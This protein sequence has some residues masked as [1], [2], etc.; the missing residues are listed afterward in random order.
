MKTKV[1]KKNS[2][3]EP[4]LKTAG[5]KLKSGFPPGI[6]VD[7]LWLYR[8]KRPSE[9][10]W[11]NDNLKPREGSFKLLKSEYRR[12]FKDFR[13]CDN[14]REEISPVRNVKPDDHLK[15][16]GSY[17]L[18]PLYKENFIQYPIERP[19]HR[20]TTSSFQIID[21]S[22]NEMREN[23]RENER[24]LTEIRSRYPPYPYQERPPL[25]KRETNLK[26][27]GDLYT[28]TEKAEKFI[29][30]LLT[31]KPPLM[32]KPT[33]LKLEGEMDI[34]TENR[35]KY[36]PYEIAP[37]P[38]LCKKF[39]NLHLEGDLNILTEKQE[40]FIR[41][42]VQKR[43][44]L[45][46]KHTNLVIEG[47]LELLPEYRRE[48]IEYKTERPKLALPVN[49]LKTDGF[50]D[51]TPDVSV[52]FQQQIHP[53][54]PNLR[55]GE[56]HEDMTLRTRLGRTTRENSLVDGPLETDESAK[57]TNHLHLEGRIDL[58]PE[59]R[60]AYIDF[61]KEVSAP[62][63]RRR[64]PES[65]LKSE[66]KMDI[67][68][69]YKCSYV[70]FPRT[71]PQVKRPENSLSSEGEIDHMTEK[72]EKYVPF[73]NVPRTGPLKRDTELKLEG[74]IECQPEYRKA[75]ID[76]LIRER[77]ERKPRPLDNLGQ[78]P[79]RIIEEEPLE[80][81]LIHAQIPTV[82]EEPQK[83]PK[84]TRNRSLSQ[85]ETS[86]FGPKLTVP[87]KPQSRSSSPKPPSRRRSRT[88][89]RNVSNSSDSDVPSRKH[90]TFGKPVLVENL[91]SRSTTPVLPM[92]DVSARNKWMR[93]S[94]V[95]S[96]SAFVV[97]DKNVKRDKWT[98]WQ[99]Y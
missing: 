87:E 73:A 31:N 1:D 99:N 66:G 2:A 14:L 57:I 53:Q 34:N 26:L 55:G 35:E 86:V 80:K 64:G 58:N 72:N 84:S 61:N 74:N 8:R 70:D 49:N 13:S 32:K 11:P 15:L 78:P 3:S 39:T 9:N 69:E 95:E 40:K 33:T 85:I 56:G 79:R 68:P 46:K 36:V 50:Y 63:T 6:T 22:E 98:P 37:R 67:T 88:V 65:H 20:P 83:R 94:S 4:D 59:Y 96:S 45:T 30:Y 89:P 91:A 29:Q 42:D 5:R 47:D 21:L 12:R 44:P 97:L 62:R 28:T 90:K 52:A 82:K 77:V 93:D 60:N 18:Q 7:E 43:P 24:L 17:E 76:Y 51:V 38:P 81:T 54:I 48:F 10:L 16:E 92:I 27:E 23:S 71:R 19:V 25:I 75:Y 41:Y